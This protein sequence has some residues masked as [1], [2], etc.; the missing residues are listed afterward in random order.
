MKTPFLL[1]IELVLVYLVIAIAVYLYYNNYKDETSLPS[2]TTPPDN[3]KNDTMK[4]LTGIANPLGYILLTFFSIYFV[5]RG[6][7]FLVDKV[8]EESDTKDKIKDIEH[9][10]QKI[11]RKV[12]EGMKKP[13]KILTKKDVIDDDDGGERGTN[14]REIERR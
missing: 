14:R 8:M 12:K 7:F 6:F 9:R 1:F 3:T 2:V 11:G 4:T 13:L 10:I 5:Y